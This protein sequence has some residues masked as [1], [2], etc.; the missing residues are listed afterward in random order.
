MGTGPLPSGLSWPE[1]EGDYAVPS[2]AVI[3]NEWRY[4]YARSMCRNVGYMF[5][6]NEGIGIRFE[7]KNLFYRFSENKEY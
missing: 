6:H 3:K 7:K 1:R 4:I 2:S 5:G